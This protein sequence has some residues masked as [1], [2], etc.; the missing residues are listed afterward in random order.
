MPDGPE[1]EAGPLQYL[2][3][4]P[5]VT[6]RHS[7]ALYCCTFTMRTTSSLRGRAMKRQAV[8][9]NGHS[10]NGRRM[11][12]FEKAARQFR[13][14]SYA[15]T[16]MADI[17]AVV[18]M[19]KGGLYNHIS[20]KQEIL[21]HVAGIAIAYLKRTTGEM[22]AIGATDPERLI[23]HGIRRRVEFACEHAD[24][25]AVL[26]KDR[27]HLAPGQLQAVTTLHRRFRRLIR[28]AI[29]VGI[30]RRAFAPTNPGVATHSIMGMTNWVYEWYD[31]G[32]S[33]TPQELGEQLSRLFLNGLRARR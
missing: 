11:E 29:V 24:V 13:E 15:A 32:G 17:A 1:S 7:R 31:P 8:A 20:S 18:G 14:K 26:T 6:E 16:S 33:L 5:G 28:E 23:A 2:R 22:Q 27:H 4:T 3:R 19:R 25:I 10:S 21:E 12:I 30:T 9:M